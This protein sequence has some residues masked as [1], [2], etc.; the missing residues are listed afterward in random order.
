MKTLILFLLV[1]L[2]AGSVSSQPVEATVAFYNVE[3]LFDPD[4][5]P[6]VNDDEFLPDGAKHWN[7]ERYWRKVVRIYQVLTA[8][9]AGEMPVIV[10]L[11]EVENRKVLEKLVYDTPL[12]KFDYRVIH[13]DSP[14]ARGID[15]ALIYRKDRFMPDTA[16]WLRVTLPDG[17]A[18][19]DILHVSG[20]LFDKTRLHCYVN[21]WPS[22]Y[23]GVVSSQ[24]RR[25]AAAITLAKSIESVFMAE[26]DPNILIM[27]DFNDEPGDATMKRITGIKTPGARHQPAIVNL[28]V[29]RSDLKDIGTI[30]HQGEWCVFDQLLVSG[31][32]IYG[33]NGL[34]IA[35]NE[36]VI[37]S[38]GFLLE[39][40]EVY[41]GHKPYRTY[42]GPAYLRGFSDHLPVKVSIRDH[43]ATR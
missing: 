5:D 13:Q 11:C 7:Y 43:P 10:G 37:F 9:G 39:P 21:H 8:L 6:L 20:R 30:K 14:D 38:A 18:T 33:R 22:R 24:A 1:A 23:G 32:L 4:D 35:E 12:R 36:A 26:D 31:A 40:D 3:N 27:G 34:K 25:M 29:K 16:E 42:I 28:S 2:Q 17:S 15:A 41:T 19:R